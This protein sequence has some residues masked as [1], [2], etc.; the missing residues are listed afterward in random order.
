MKD[1]ATTDYGRVTVSVALANGRAQARAVQ[2]GVRGSAFLGAVGGRN[3]ARPPWGWFDVKERDESAGAW[4]F[5]PAATVRR[6]FKLGEE[7][8]VAYTW[9][10]FLSIGAQR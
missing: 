5:D 1:G 2:V 6:H 3:M 8:S 9:Q 10:P 4:F 7:F